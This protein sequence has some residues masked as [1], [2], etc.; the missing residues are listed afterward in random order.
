[1]VDRDLIDFDRLVDIFALFR[2]AT[3][4]I[5]NVGSFSYGSFLRYLF[6][7]DS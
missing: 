5:Y 7:T 4:A 1:M 3:N 2:D 6:T